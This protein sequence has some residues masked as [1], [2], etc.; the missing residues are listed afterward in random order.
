MQCRDRPASRVL[1]TRMEAD[2]LAGGCSSRE[3]LQQ[4]WDR[5]MVLPRRGGGR[6]SQ[7][8]SGS[9]EVPGRGS[10]NRD[11]SVIALTWALLKSCSGPVRVKNAPASCLGGRDE[12]SGSSV[13]KVLFTALRESEPPW[14]GTGAGYKVF[15]YIPVSWI[16]LGIPC[17]LASCPL[18]PCPN[19]S[20]LCV[21]KG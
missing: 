9:G 13:Q 11:L 6:W 12:E 18:I 2:S 8:R 4:R 21:H 15:P 20:V 16:C 5:P 17:C 14:V 19:P 1:P 3:M 7:H 10:W